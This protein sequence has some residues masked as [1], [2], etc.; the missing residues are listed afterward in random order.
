MNGQRDHAAI[1]AGLREQFKDG[2]LSA[3]RDNQRITDEA[4]LAELATVFLQQAIRE[5]TQLAVLV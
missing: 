3:M 1:E 5:L 2:R 4:Q